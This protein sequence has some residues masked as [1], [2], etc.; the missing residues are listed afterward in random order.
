VIAA[1]TRCAATQV[2][3]LTAERDLDIPAALQ[4]HFGHNLMG[5]YAEVVGGGAIAT[6]D[7]LAMRRI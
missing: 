6:G 3:P 5:I 7:E 4:Q 1:I 2:N